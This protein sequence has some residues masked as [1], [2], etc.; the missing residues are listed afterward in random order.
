[1]SISPET[2][3]IS[4]ILRTG[5]MV[6]ALQTGL[7]KDQFHAHPDEWEWLE[8]YFMKYKK[9]PSKVAFKQ[10]F[11][12]FSVKAVDDVG[13]FTSEV[14]ERHAAM[15]MTSDMKEILRLI[16]DGDLPD[17]MSRFRDSAVSLSAEMGDGSNDS[18]IITSWDDTYDE[19]AKR[20]ER[21]AAHGMAGIP[22]GFT[23]LD[24]RTGGPQAGHV[25]IVGARLG[26][27]KSWAMMRMATAALLEGYTIQYNALEQTRAEVAMRIHTFLSSAVG[28]EV[29]RNMDL[30]QGRNFDLKSYKLFLK[31]MKDEI[32]GKMHVS[33][34]S[35]GR[36]SPLTIAAQIER[37]NPDIVFVDYLTLM[38]K[39]GDG[40]WK[41]VA[42]LSADLKELASRY[43]IPIVAAAQLN[44]EHG[45][46]K[47][48]A[49]PEALAQAD[50][51][52]QDADAVITMKQASKSVLRMKLA[53]FRHGTAGYQWNCCFQPGRGIF[54]EV[55][56]SEAQRLMD[57]DEDRE[58]E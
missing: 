49:G 7:N 46:G 15:R 41:S 28:K 21:V 10:Q 6:T 48:P 29:F 38:E 9:V 51:I 50:A 43:Q 52:G 19:V 23:T 17:A 2:L 44:R 24:E 1:M 27:G 53:K 22:T 33:D 54:K 16:A 45:L 5:D 12:E 42:K 26:Q 11:P 14:R 37:N 35:R 47:E 3:L 31:G 20:V 39:T 34:T 36:V 18:D 55:S 58:D 32:A 30:M 56:Y 57:E 8:R 13:H 40:D 25:W 4:A